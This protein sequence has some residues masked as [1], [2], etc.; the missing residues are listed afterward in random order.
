LEFCELVGA[1]PPEVGRLQHLRVLALPGNELSGGI[2]P[3]IYGLSGLA[4]L[5]LS[6]NALEGA[7]PQELRRLEMLEVLDLESNRLSGRIP[8]EV[9]EPLKELTWLDLG[10]NNLEGS[11]PHEL[12]SLEKLVC[13]DLIHNSLSGPVPSTLGGMPALT[14]LDLSKNKLTGPI[15]ETL[16][17]LSAL[18]WLDLN[19]NWLEGMIPESFKS[20]AKLEVLDLSHNVLQGRIP[21]QLGRLTELRFLG[22]NENFLLGGIPPSLGGL[23]K[24]QILDLADNQLTDRIPKSLARLEELVGMFLYRNR[25][26]GHIP[27]EFRG[28]SNLAFFAVHENG[29]YGRVPQMRLT[30]CSLPAC[31]DQMLFTTY[32]N[33]LSCW[34]PPPV[35]LEARGKLKGAVVHGNMFSLPVPEW[36]PNEMDPVHFEQ[37]GKL[38]RVSG[39]LLAGVLVWFLLV[40]LMLQRETWPFL[41]DEVLPS[42]RERRPEVQAHRSL[43]IWAAL[44]TGL[45]IIGFLPACYLGSAYTTCGDQLAHL[46]ITYLARSR[47]SESTVGALELVHFAMVWR[48]LRS[49]PKNRASGRTSPD[50]QL[51]LHMV[52]RKVAGWVGWLMVLAAVAVLPVMYAV[53]K[54]LPWDN[55]IKR[56]IGEPCYLGIYYGAP[57]AS[58]VLN[59]LLLPC[60][61]ELYSR[62]TNMRV[63]RLLTLTHFVCVWIAPM[64]AVFVM[65][66]ECGKGW[67]SFWLACE[68]HGFDVEVVVG[69]KTLQVLNTRDICSTPTLRRMLS[70]HNGG[71][72]RDILATLTPLLCQQL[73]IEA[74]VFPILY[75]LTWMASE[76]SESGELQ[77]RR[78]GV[79]T[80]FTPEE[81]FIQLDIWAATVVMWG[82]L[83][84]LMLPLI[85]LA[86]SISFVMLRLE[87]RYF[88]RGLEEDDGGEADK[89]DHAGL[90]ISKVN[91]KLSAG[92][93]CVFLLFFACETVCFGLS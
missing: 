70:Q 28:L 30:S 25:L 23:S 19:D 72:S 33:H 89:K 15:P 79:R 38:Q 56:L 81:Y 85:V 29:L 68:G 26:A 2:P 31:T 3:E 50:W 4:E 92:L 82:P 22:A 10:N 20:L 64:C 39:I 87:S 71:C 83:V 47:I 63:K 6:R 88:G 75:L 45:G 55:T 60:V 74:V 58:A 1:I 61:A 17:N 9:W 67:R 46:S 65:N 12:G 52:A 77:M 93:L 86:V 44:M 57:A 78:L 76:R 18:T 11:I 49:L 51:W 34:I 42:W 35:G 5:D 84:P 24:L 54:A 32:G 14:T 21:S 80:S 8:S 41:R 43:L 40:A 91:M 69:D 7:I 59:S 16:G 73:A 62:R 27:P 36:L 53:V 37:P 66:E 48:F 13:L 90:H